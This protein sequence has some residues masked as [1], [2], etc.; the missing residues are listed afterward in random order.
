MR[1]FVCSVFCLCACVL[2]ADAGVLGIL[3]DSGF[4]SELS[5]QN[6]DGVRRLEIID[7]NLYASTGNGI[8][9]YSAAE[10]TWRCWAMEGIN[11]LDF[12]VNGDDIIAITVPEDQGGLRGVEIARIVRHNRYDCHTEDIMDAEMGYEYGGVRLTYVM[13]MAQHPEKPGTIMVSAY[14]GIWISED[15]GTTWNLKTNTSFGYNENQFMGWHPTETEVMF[16]TSENNYFA[17]QILRSGDGGASWDSIY[18]DSSGDNS[19][20]HLAF[21]PKDSHHILYSGE[22]VIFESWD[23]GITWDCVYADGDL[24]D[25]TAIGYAYNVMF[26]PDDADKVYAVGC[27]ARS[28]T[29]NIFKSPDS[30]KS[31]HRIAQ[32]D[33]FEDQ[34]Y[35]VHESTIMD[36]K[37]YVYTRGGIYTYDT[38]STSGASHIEA[39][40]TYTPQPV[41]DLNGRKANKMIPGTVYIHQGKKFTVRR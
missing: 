35:W 33:S 15:F 27:D 3:E 9:Q 34:E 5:I 37:I 2:C 26:D 22:G 41:F 4:P 12:K 14:P 1:H 17:A 38:G 21:D 8:Y 32:S 24:N 16:Y 6:K 20:H 18:P 36:G 13:R 29:I 40:D 39:Y 25:G 23:Y 28:H 19:C 7:D 30:G 31:W 11:V 10:N